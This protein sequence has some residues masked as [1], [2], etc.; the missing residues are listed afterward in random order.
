MKKNVFFN[1]NKIIYIYIYNFF[2]FFFRDF[3]GLSL[4]R[5]GPDG[6]AAGVNRKV[7]RVGEKGEIGRQ[8]FLQGIS[9]LELFSEIS[10]SE[11]CILSGCES[12]I[13]CDHK[14]LCNSDLVYKTISLLAKHPHLLIL[15]LVLS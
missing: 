5:C 1:N 3:R 9:E 6:G 7:I 10:K 2:L 15:A 14:I 13:S 8:K 4:L 12:I 11:I